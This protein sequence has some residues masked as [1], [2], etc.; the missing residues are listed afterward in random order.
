MVDTMG[1]VVG[2]YF[3]VGPWSKRWSKLTKFIVFD[4][5]MRV[6]HDMAIFHKHGYTQYQDSFG[7][8]SWKVL[9]EAFRG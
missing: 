8:L 1:L 3:L 4:H 6:C 9:S 2:G 5:G 7:G